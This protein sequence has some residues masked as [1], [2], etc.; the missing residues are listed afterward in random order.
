MIKDTLLK[1]ANGLSSSLIR[2][3][4]DLITELKKMANTRFIDLPS[5]KVTTMLAE[6]YKILILNNN[7]GK[8]EKDKPPCNKCGK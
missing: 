8:T 2:D 4:Q 5:M 6:V 3:E 7:N 1:K